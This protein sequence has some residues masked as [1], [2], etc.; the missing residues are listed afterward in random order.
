MRE[1]FN[2]SLPTCLHG[3]HR[4]TFTFSFVSPYECEDSILKQATTTSF[5]TVTYVQYIIAF[6]FLY[7]V[8]YKMLVAEMR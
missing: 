5:Q 2:S 4:G 3:V 8:G 1:A 7:T 6:L